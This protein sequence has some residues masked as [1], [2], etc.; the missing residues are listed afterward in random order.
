MISF[1]IELLSCI[2]DH[3][4]KRDQ[5]VC[6]FVCYAWHVPAKRAF[7]NKVKIEEKYDDLNYNN[8]FRFKRFIKCISQTNRHLPTPGQFIQSLV[9]RFEIALE[10]KFMP[11]TTD[12]QLLAAACPNLQELH[13][14][15]NM[16]WNDIMSIDNQH[17]WKRL[18]KVPQFKV[19]AEKQS[20]D[21]FLYFKS[22][23]SYLHI[24]EWQLSSSSS[25]QDFVAMIKSF[26]H[27]ETLKITTQQGFTN[28]HDIIPT[29]IECP[30]I[31]QLIMAS[32]S[33]AAMPALTD[34][35]LT[36]PRLRQLKLT[37]SSLD[38]RLIYTIANCFPDLQKLVLRFSQAT[39]DP[40]VW[41]DD[42]QAEMSHLV[43]FLAGLHQARIDLFV[44]GYLIVHHLVKQLY[45]ASSATASTRPKLCITYGSCSSFTTGQPDLSFHKHD[46]VARLNV[47][48]QGH[49]PADLLVNNLPHMFFLQENGYLIDQLSIQ[50]PSSLLG[51]PQFVQSTLTT[52]CPNLKVFN[53][54]QG[55]FDMET[56]DLK[57]SSSQLTC[58]SLERSLITLDS[59]FHLSKLY[60]SSL[61]YLKLENCVLPNSLENIAFINMPYTR[62]K[63]MT[64]LQDYK[65]HDIVLVSV[66][67]KATE[68]TML[69]HYLTRTEN[70]VPIIAPT[71]VPL[72]GI[73]PVSLSI[74]CFSLNQ[75]QLNSCYMTI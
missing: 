30:N 15:S 3:T 33:T 27:L 24:A 38:P 74:N 45:I 63:K 20:I 44:P 51:R 66:T 62:F 19:T 29:L 31:V 4:S 17:Y 42:L 21:K 32:N 67:E 22:T 35:N 75:L 7:Y 72:K 34:R 40:F 11:T 59:L 37:S 71:N 10:A 57:L 6:Q 9:I 13:F 47:R 52:Y 18:R 73:S 5:L 53:L 65:D 55:S 16:F 14:P 68:R 50:F 41:S 64:I 69:Y 36:V 12:F 28:L 43:R 70:L 8:L 61:E 23:L 2:F 1:P 46:S 39:N 48:Y 49:L 54:V 25:R 26:T 60:A 58:V 56:S